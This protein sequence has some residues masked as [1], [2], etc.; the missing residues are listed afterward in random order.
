M[1][2]SACKYGSAKIHIPPLAS[3][4]FAFVVT[5]SGAVCLFLSGH[6]ARLLQSTLRLLSPLLGIEMRV[7]C[8]RLLGGRA[9]T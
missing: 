2:E 1:Q 3:A 8:D 4:H 5:A 6:L 7:F 9:S